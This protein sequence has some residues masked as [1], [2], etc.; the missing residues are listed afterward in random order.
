MKICF[1]ILFFV[2]FFQYTVSSQTY[3]DT[4]F[5]LPLGNTIKLTSSNPRFEALGNSHFTFTLG[6]TPIINGTDP[7][8]GSVNTFV[9]IGSTVKAIFK[10]ENYIKLG[11]PSTY[12]F[13]VN[14]DNINIGSVTLITDNVLFNGEIT[15]M[16]VNRDIVVTRND[17]NAIFKHLPNNINDT[18]NDYMGGNRFFETALSG[19]NIVNSE[20][21]ILALGEMN[22]A[23][24]ILH[25][26]N[27]ISAA[28]SHEVIYSMNGRQALDQGEIF[29]TS[30]P[31][32][33]WFA[34]LVV[35]SSSTEE[36]ETGIEVGSDV[37]SYGGIVSFDVHLPSLISSR[38]GFV[39]GGGIGFSKSTGYYAETSNEVG[40]FIGGIYVSVAHLGMRFVFSSTY[41]GMLNEVLYKVNEEFLKSDFLTHNLESAL[42][43]AYDFKMGDFFISPFVGVNHAFYSQPTL[44]FQFENDVVMITRS[45]IKNTLF[46]PVGLTFSYD[47]KLSD[48][49][50]LTPSLR[51][52]AN[53]TVFDTG[54]DSLW[55]FTE[56]DIRMEFK[57]TENVGF[58][59]ANFNLS[60]QRSSVMV[61]GD[62]TL[63]FLGGSMTHFASI[64]S[65][66]FF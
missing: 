49:N 14:V 30:I 34:P 42:H 12:G 18:L 19:D 46:I 10:L 8:G 24:G 39:T 56:P 6:N 35:F 20:K 58:L 21:A 22:K 23:A 9:T 26:N 54:M 15:G 63:R 32:S 17:A 28:V 48:R 47:F 55:L 5:E 37:S 33:V 45:S 16:G 11:T 61:Y 7:F 59:D 41:I 38:L 3:N 13:I 40:Y 31:M 62:Y 25:L 53:I 60:W 27:V 4:D 57:T 2:C 64:G 1:F 44:S 29:F 65:R 66:W 51:V 50:I 36:Y 43:F 52:N